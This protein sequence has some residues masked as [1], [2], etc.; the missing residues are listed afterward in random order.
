MVTDKLCTQ[1]LLMRIVMWYRLQRAEKCY[2]K[3][4]L[5]IP[6][7]KYLEKIVKATLSNIKRLE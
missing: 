1:V 3:S 7:C 6:I 5:I 4:T 2:E